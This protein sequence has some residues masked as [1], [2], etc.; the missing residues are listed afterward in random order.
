ML[1]DE[2]AGIDCLNCGFEEAVKTKT[3]S[4]S[5]KK[6]LRWTKNGDTICP[7]CG[8]SVTYEDYISE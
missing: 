2:T 3:E 7:V 5:L 4:D 8:N 6:S 1:N